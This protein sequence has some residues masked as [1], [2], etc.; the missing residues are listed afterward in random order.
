MIQFDKEG[1]RFIEQS[2]GRS[3]LSDLLP[4]H[5]RADA[6]HLALDAGLAAAAVARV[7]V[8]A[9]VAA[10]LLP[11]EPDGSELRLLAGVD[12]GDAGGSQEGPAPLRGQRL[13]EEAVVHLHPVHV[14]VLVRYVLQSQQVGLGALHRAVPRQLW[15][16]VSREL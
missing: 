7:A 3:S 14:E 5:G 15:A 8:Q 9:A 12:A 10:A 11:R 1:T 13:E 6:S 4:A 2:R 16:T